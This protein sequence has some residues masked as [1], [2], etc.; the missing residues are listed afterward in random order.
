MGLLAQGL[1][2]G[3]PDLLVFDVPTKAI[4]NSTD[5]YVGVAMELKSATGTLSEEQKRWL[6]RLS[7]CGWRVSV[8]RSTAQAIAV[9]E[10]MYPTG[11]GKGSGKGSGD[12]Q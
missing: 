3:A 9:L 11:A 12:D 10:D 6:R 2:P 1:S 8:P 7:D 5:R 4:E